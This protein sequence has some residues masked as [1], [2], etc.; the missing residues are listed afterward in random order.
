MLIQ[1][2]IPQY[3][4]K[5]LDPTPELNVQ[6]RSNSQIHQGHVQNPGVVLTD[7]T[8][9]IPLEI[10]FW[11]NN[12]RTE[13]AR[14]STATLFRLFNVT[15]DKA[16]P[17]A[18]E[19]YQ[20]LRESLPE[21]LK[22]QL[23]NDEKLRFIQRDPDLIALDESLSFQAI[24]L[25]LLDLIAAPALSTERAEAGAITFHAMPDNVKHNLLA[26]TE[27]INAELNTYLNDIGPNDPSFDLLLKASNEMRETFKLLKK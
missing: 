21:E 4:P 10:L 16:P 6:Q 11:I 1:P 20:R 2:S 14:P 8:Y 27:T 3:N 7:D 9:K 17:F 18:L 24:G 5:D 13:L 19:Q 25:A 26:L 23:L 12:N 15:G 22:G